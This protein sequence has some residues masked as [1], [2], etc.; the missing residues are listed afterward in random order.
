[1]ADESR[2]AAPEVPDPRYPLAAGRPTAT[3]PSLS[4]EVIEVAAGGDRTADMRIQVEEVPGEAQVVHVG[5]EIDLSTAAMLHDELMQACARADGQRVRVD[6]ADVSF[7]GSAGLQV[8]LGIH[9]LCRR[10]GVV[11]EVTNPPR[12]ALRAIQISGLDRVLSVR[13][14]DNGFDTEAEPG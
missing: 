12:A 6:L 4:E 11:F 13:V 5:G 10:C 7:L 9:S 14:P 3:S 8:L 1:M 2:R